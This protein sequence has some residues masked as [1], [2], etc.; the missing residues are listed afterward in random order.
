MGASLL[1]AVVR[2]AAIVARAR[3]R[4]KDRRRVARDAERASSALDG[5]A[6]AA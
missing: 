2:S 5:I 1:G 6:A 3:R 4:V